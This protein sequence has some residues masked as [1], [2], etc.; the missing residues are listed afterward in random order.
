MQADVRPRRLVYV[1]YDGTNHADIEDN[2]CVNDGSQN[3]GASPN[4]LVINDDSSS[5]VK[6]NTLV[7]FKDSYGNAGGI[8]SI[9]SKSSSGSGTTL[10]DNIATGFDNCENGNCR[11][12]AESH[13]LFV[14][15]GPGGTGDVHGTPAYQGGAC[16]SLTSSTGPFCSEAWSN[17]L[18]TASSPGHNAADDGTDMGAYGSG[19]VTP[20]GP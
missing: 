1:S 9:G 16:G 10:T 19:P 13:N 12:Y 18:L 8:M 2:V 15:G 6:H 20:G 11:P 3:N 5:I 17:Y 4:V 14:Q 7:A